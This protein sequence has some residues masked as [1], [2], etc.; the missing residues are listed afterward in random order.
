MN[1]EDRIMEM[2]VAIRDEVRALRKA[3]D[4]DPAVDAIDVSSPG[5]SEIDNL[6][7]TFS[8]SPADEQPAPARP[9]V[10]PDIDDAAI[11][12]LLDSFSLPAVTPAKKPA[13]SSRPLPAA[14]PH[15]PKQASDSK[16]D[17]STDEL[18]KIF[19]GK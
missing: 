1:N 4:K 11:D 9:A 17:L 3:I 12:N 8:Q 10:E 15:A 16:F 19:D 14:E 13:E 5:S 6:L 7:D 18:E 2:L